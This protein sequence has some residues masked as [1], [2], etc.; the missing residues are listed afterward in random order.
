MKYI[1][2]TP[3]YS[4]L[5]NVIMSYEM[6][7]ALSYISNRTIILP[8]NVWLLFISKTQQKK[9][10]VNILK[11]FDESTIRKNFDC[12][13]FYDVPEFKNKYD[14]LQG[15]WS[16]TFNIENV[17][18][19]IFSVHYGT[20]PDGK[21]QIL[22]DQ[23]QLFTNT[24]SSNSDFIKF[25]CNRNVLNLTTVRNKFIHFERNLF[26]HYW[27]SIYPGDENKR[28][29][30]KK[31]I[32]ESF[33][34]NDR[35]YDLAK[36]VKH[37]IGNYNAVHIRRN[38]F[39]S[40]RPYHMESVSDSQKLLDALKKYFEKDIPLYVATD[41]KNKEF[42]DDIKKE[43]QLYFYEDFEY[44]LDDLDNAIVEQVICS[45]SELFYGTYM[46]T[47]T[48]RI[49][50][51]RGLENKQADDHFGINTDK[52]SFY[53]TTKPIPWYYCKDEKIWNWNDPSY[54]QWKIEKNGVY[55]NGK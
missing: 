19:D 26:N 15:Y 31:V 32:N 55:V 2:F 18:E 39:L 29:E 23:N 40:T 16:Y 47:Y 21:Q 45:Q 1:S 12:I 11:I 5:A 20:T 49:N 9:D 54:P 44:E 50:V 24:Q 48:K 28:N 52:P 10:Y 4:G 42:F 53:D 41:E 14:Q 36:K 37:K 35:Y 8:P 3:H 30:L 13:D 46:S 6:A 7:F 22:T 33:R 27:Y 43:Y 38:D 34:Y 25:S 17:I 51:M